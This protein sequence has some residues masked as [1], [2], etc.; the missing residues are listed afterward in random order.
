MSNLT[1][2]LAKLLDDAR[3][4]PGAAIRADLA[5]GL[6]LH[7]RIRGGTFSLAISRKA[8]VKPSNREWEIVLAHLPE[9]LPETQPVLVEK[10]DRIY[11]GATWPVDE[12]VKIGGA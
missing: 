9:P 7:A 3:R 6:R 4:N 12:L 2:T 8:P 10:S 5:R 11:L 1:D